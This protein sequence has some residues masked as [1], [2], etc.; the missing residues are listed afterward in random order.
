MAD[1]GV[2]DGVVGAVSVQANRH[3]TV[4]AGGGHNGISPGLRAG[5]HLY[6]IE[7]MA[8]PYM[9]M[10]AGHYFD[11]QANALAQGVATQAGLD[12]EAALE[13]VGYSFASAHLGLKLGS[14]S[15]AFYLQAGVSVMRTSATIRESR[16]LPMA[17]AMEP[18]A[19]VDV[20]TESIFRI[21]TPSGRIG[22]IAYFE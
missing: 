22:L 7:H 12:A 16:D 5:V 18:G 4:H 14:A 2:P 8:A 19:T 1:V 20:M 10:E 13:R 6:A 21:W 11:G 3:V 17:P 15:A 9:A